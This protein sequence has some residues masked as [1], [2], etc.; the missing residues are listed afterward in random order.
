VSPP[1]TP[2]A[3][4]EAILRESL[5]EVH[6]GER[7]R[8]ALAP[9]DGEL[10]VAGRPLAPGGK[11]VVLAA[12]KAAAVMAASLED[13]A[14][15]RVA[16]GLAVTKDGHGVPLRRIALREAG[17]PVPDARS[18][19]AGQEALRMVSSCAADDVLLVLLSGGASALLACPVSG[20]TLEALAETTSLLLGS[21]AGIDELNTVRK[22]LTEV[23]GGRLAR[24]AR[25]ARIEV[26]AV[27]DVPGDR[28]DVIG[29]GPCAADPSSFGDALEVLRRRGLL[30]RIPAGVRCHLEAG[31]RGEVEETPKPGDASLARVRT[32]LLACNRDALAAA[33]RAA[34]CR[35]LRPLRL[36]E[37]LCGE[38]R[39]VG[40]RLA[41]L[42]RSLRA[43]EPL[44]LVAG[45][46]TTVTLR[47][48]GRGGRSQELALAAAL[49][50]AGEDGIALLAAGTDGTDGPTDAAG[51]FADGGTRERGRRR[52]VDARACL[53]R[54]DAY[55]FFLREGGL[56]RTGPTG[57]NVMDLVLLRVGPPGAP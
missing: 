37:G 35:G 53:A 50:L 54:N 8:A 48:E 25:S 26:L 32:T 43:R 42:G 2:R 18:E 17:H 34:A 6:A 33:E 51:A 28:L 49:E 15:A 16:G 20:V 22:H 24:A 13:L 56:L 38:A 23:S 3:I 29:S 55:A 30:A 4:L 12:G 1:R 45:G 36:S 7:L 47:G 57:T 40:R 14:G 5:H 27:S 44:C 21:G 11:L 9:C 19:A 46:E 52:G 31:R 39:E 10:A 41:G